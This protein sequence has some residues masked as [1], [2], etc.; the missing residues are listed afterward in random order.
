M[1][2]VPSMRPDSPR[3]AEPRE[4]WT[5]GHWLFQP[6]PVFGRASVRQDPVDWNGMGYQH[7]CS[8][9]WTDH[10]LPNGH[11]I[12]AAPDLAIDGQFLL[13]R[14]ADLELP[15]EL[16]RDW[17]CHVEPALERFAAALACARGDQP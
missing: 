13:D 10:L 3:D 7:I 17:F 2:T 14:L 15:E 11:L 4:P 5:P 1:S 8:F 16:A 6:K 9:P 12:A